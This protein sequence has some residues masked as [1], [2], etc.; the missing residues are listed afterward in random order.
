MGGNSGGWTW[1]PAGLRR[2]VPPAMG[3]ALM[4]SG[5]SHAS[6]TIVYADHNAANV[7]YGDSTYSGQDGSLGN[8]FGSIQAAYHYL[9]G[10]AGK[11][12]IRLK[13][14]TYEYADIGVNEYNNSAGFLRFVS[15]NWFPSTDPVWTS[16]KLVAQNGPGTVHIYFHF[17][18]QG[19]FPH[20]SNAAAYE[21]EIDH[22]EMSAIK[23]LF[24]PGATHAL[25]G[26]ILEALKITVEGGGTL[27]GMTATS[28]GI[29]QQFTF[30]NVELYLLTDPDQVPNDG[31]GLDGGDPFGNSAL[32]VS[33]MPQAD[34]N[35]SRLEFNNSKIYVQPK[36]KYG[37]A[38][39][40]GQLWTQGVVFP[41]GFVDG[42]GT[43]AIYFWD[44]ASYKIKEDWS[45]ATSGVW[46]SSRNPN[47]LY[48]QENDAGGA[49]RF[50]SNFLPI[51]DPADRDNDGL[52]DAW[53]VHYGKT[54]DFSSNGD[55][56]GDGMIDPDEYVA[57]TDPT[58]S[59][60]VL[61]LRIWETN[62]S[63]WIRFTTIPTNQFDQG[64]NRYYS[65]WKT[66]TPDQEW[67]G[68]ENLT[69]FQN[70]FSAPIPVEYP[71]KSGAAMHSFRVSVW[72]R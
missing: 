4:L 40:V 33:H 17:P 21:P 67:N 5:T 6:D 22:D 11:H 45:G 59:N 70:E 7:A 42:K 56:D 55:F 52:F 48:F 35:S 44:G 61:K 3:L 47:K 12:E 2:I 28:A 62:N 39:F 8:P 24:N 16:V 31:I 29:A 46:A 1:T 23:G 65:L 51:P 27:I 63:T 38:M 20:G 13:P 68:V 36:G 50:L 54:G 19:S 25:P 60:D 53:E 10:V 14:G 69:N 15:N 9:W 34:L 57:G 41:A 18:L 58:D 66:R 72:L 43:S 49:N 64:L 32:F 37:T 71:D 30:N 26:M